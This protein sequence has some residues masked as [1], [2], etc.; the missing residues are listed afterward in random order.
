[1]LMLIFVC[2]LADALL[3]L[4]LGL[5]PNAA[6]SSSPRLPIETASTFINFDYMYGKGSKGMTFPHHE[7]IASLSRVQAQVSAA[8]PQR[9][10]PRSSETWMTMLGPTSVGDRR[11]LV[12]KDV[13]FMAS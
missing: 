12:E 8:E 10:F 13:S 2:T 9:V 11:L 1:M 4:V 5:R 3:I 7:P 6:R